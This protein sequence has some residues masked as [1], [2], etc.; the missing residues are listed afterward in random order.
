MEDIKRNNGKWEKEMVSFYLQYRK[1][2][3]EKLNIQAYFK[4]QY[5]VKNKN[6]KACYKVILSSIWNS[7]TRNIM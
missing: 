7:P 5:P 6:Y 4:N 3:K 1:E 2:E